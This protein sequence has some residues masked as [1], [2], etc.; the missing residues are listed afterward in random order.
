MWLK[1][2]A[3]RMHH[4]LHVLSARM[5]DITESTS[6]IVCETSLTEPKMTGLMAFCSGY[7]PSQ[8]F[9]S[10]NIDDNLNMVNQDNVLIETLQALSFTVLWDFTKWMAAMDN[11]NGLYKAGFTD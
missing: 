9:K 6:L 1:Q 3:G 11:D 5:S 8:P 7:G 4:G 2:I 10:L